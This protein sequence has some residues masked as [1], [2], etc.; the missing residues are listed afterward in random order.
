[1]TEYLRGHTAAFDVIISADTLVYFGRLEEVVA[2]AANAL[3]PG[4]S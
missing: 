4:G 2:A 1:L 3:R